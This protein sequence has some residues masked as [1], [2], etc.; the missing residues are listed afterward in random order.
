MFQCTLELRKVWCVVNAGRDAA[1]FRL[2][3]KYDVRFKM[4]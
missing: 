3:Q 2:S 1:I 4:V